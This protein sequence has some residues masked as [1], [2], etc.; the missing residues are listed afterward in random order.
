MSCSFK[1]CKI[2]S[3]IE[4]TIECWLCTNQ[5]HAKCAGIGAR[6]VDALYGDNIGLRWCCTKCRK[7]SVDFYKFYKDSMTE[8]SEMS[9]DLWKI[10]TR[11]KQLASLL[12]KF[13]D[14]G[15]FVNSPIVA[16]QKRKRTAKKTSNKSLP[17]R[18]GVAGSTRSA[19]VESA[20]PS[21][22]ADVLF[23]SDGWFNQLINH[24]N[25]IIILVD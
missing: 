1:G 10:Y 2:V 17:P 6:I 22:S 3:D 19:V 24:R 23:A 9:R 20:A 16:G 21:V 14:L 25:L 12:D 11:F 13:P 4:T 8:V 18:T 7:I 15:D 5:W